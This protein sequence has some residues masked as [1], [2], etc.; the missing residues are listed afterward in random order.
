MKGQKRASEATDNT[1]VDLS[2]TPDTYRGEVEDYAVWKARDDP[3]L[4]HRVREQFRTRPESIVLELR[5]KQL[6]EENG[7]GVATGEN[8]GSGGFD[9]QCT[10][11]GGDRFDVEV[12]S[13]G[14]DPLEEKLGIPQN[15]RGPF[16]HAPFQGWVRSECLRHE[17]KRRQL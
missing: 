2:F 3:E 7:V 5:T 1:H 15:P 6:L 12:V 9:F 8:I 4:G 13:A 17:R 14:V 10:S 16:N 11:S